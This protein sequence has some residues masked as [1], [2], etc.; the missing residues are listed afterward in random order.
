MHQTAFLI[1]RSVADVYV[2]KAHAAESTGKYRVAIEQYHNAIDAMDK[3]QNSP[4]AQDCILQYR[5]KIKQLD[6]LA[7][8]QLAAKTAVEKPVVTQDENDNKLVEQWDR[9]MTEE[10]QWKKKK[11][12]DA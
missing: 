10:D 3:A 2:T 5:K 4:L 9:L 7:S 11:D 12:Y 6:K 8:E 1:A